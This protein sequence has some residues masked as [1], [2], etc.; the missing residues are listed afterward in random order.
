MSVAASAKLNKT[1]KQQYLD[2]PQG[3]EVQATYVWID[4][5]GEGLRSKTRT[6]DGELKSLQGESIFLCTTS[7]C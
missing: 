2:L 7:M 4:G 5:S 6:L 3:D 1:V